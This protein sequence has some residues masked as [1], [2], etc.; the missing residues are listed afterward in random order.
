[1]VKQYLNAKIKTLNKK[2]KEKK[3]P[4]DKF[5]IKNVSTNQLGIVKTFRYI[6]IS[7]N[8]I[9]KNIYIKIQTII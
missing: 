8:G 6:K 4:K 2:K 7:N 5:I 9:E 3:D 1:M